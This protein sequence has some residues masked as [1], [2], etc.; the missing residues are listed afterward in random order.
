MNNI[1]TNKIF[2]MILMPIFKLQNTSTSA[3]ANNKSSTA[4]N[5]STNR[6]NNFNKKPKA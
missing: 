1:H 4:R 2:V 6:T 5:T 3:D